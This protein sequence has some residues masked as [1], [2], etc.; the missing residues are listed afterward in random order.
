M[1]RQ[2]PE[3]SILGTEKTAH[4][5]AVAHQHVVSPRLSAAGFLAQRCR[6]LMLGFKQR[7]TANGCQLAI[8]VALLA[9]A[10]RDSSFSAGA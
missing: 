9:P 10:V 7:Q 2:L 5:L 6:H 3:H 1:T 8:H 4:A